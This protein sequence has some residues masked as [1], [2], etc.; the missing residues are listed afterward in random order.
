LAFSL[1]LVIFITTLITSLAFINFNMNYVGSSDN[2]ALSEGKVSIIIK[3][4]SMA[5]IE[6]KEV[7]KSSSNSVASITIQE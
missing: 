2:K 6:E 5:N 1:L 3:E 7:Q 4:P